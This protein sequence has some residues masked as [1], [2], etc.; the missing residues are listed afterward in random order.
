[1]VSIL[2]W[3][4][5]LGFF[6]GAFLHSTYE[7]PQ[8]CSM[9]EEVLY[10]LITILSETANASK[11]PLKIA[12]RREIV[13]ALAMG[14]CTFSDLVKRVATRLVDDVCFERVLREVS[15]FKLPE[16]ITDSGMYELNHE[17]FDEV[18]PFFYHYTRN[19]REEVEAKLR[20]R[21]KKI[22]GVSDPVIVPK[23]FG[24]VSGPFAEISS[25]FESVVLQVMF[26][27]FYDILLMTDNA[28]NA[29][30]SAEAILDQAMHL[31]MLA[32]VER[33]SICE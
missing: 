19:K 26:Y 10:V 24:V 30:G 14:S 28:G 21:L 9:E 6:S 20:E 11:M 29:P 3:F 1:M 12:V 7:G 2:D 33:G 32:I 13:H 22:S 18:N 25:A 5:L 15:R 17:F 23:P 31:I 27:S 4:G 16:S 8:L